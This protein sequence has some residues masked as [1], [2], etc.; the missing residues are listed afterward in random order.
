MYRFM[1]RRCEIQAFVTTNTPNYL[2]NWS[3]RLSACGQLP[4]RQ[5]RNFS[6]SNRPLFAGRQRLVAATAG[7]EL[8]GIQP[9]VVR[10]EHELHA[11]DNVVATLRFQRGS[12]A[13]AKAEASPGPSSG[14]GFWGRRVRVAVRG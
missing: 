3:I 10:R 1:T 9:A 6:G 8:L 5:A 2:G 14:R 12:L 7:E 4:R 11:G 13:D